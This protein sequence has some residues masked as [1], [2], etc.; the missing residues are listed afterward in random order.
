MRDILKQLPTM[1]EVFCRMFPDRVELDFTV[2]ICTYNG[3][4]RVPE[5]LNC[6]CW[7]LNVAD[8]AWEVIVVDNNSHDETAATVARYQKQ[9]PHPYPLRYVFEPKQGAGFA[10]QRAIQCAHSPLVGFL[11]DDNLPSLTWVSAAYHFA[12]RHP[13]AGVYGS[14]IRGDF[15]IN[16]PD[17]FDRIASLLALTE[18]GPSPI[19]YPPEKKVL[20]PG[21]GMV[22]RRQAWI[23]HVPPDKNLGIKVGKRDAAED[24][25]AVLY[26]QK[27]GW[28]IWYNPAMRL[29]HRIPKNRLKRDYL[30]GLCRGIGL[31]RYRTRM[32]SL[33]SWQ[34]PLWLWLYM[35]NDF[36]KV[37][38]HLIRH[39]R[40]VWTDTVTACEMT[41]Y[42]FSLI[43]PF[44]IWQ[45]SLKALLTPTA[46]GDASQETPDNAPVA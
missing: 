24:L 44:Y 32:L 6:L 16:P 34:R 23:D 12:Q 46:K 13:H 42:L 29:Y 27:G 33:P 2:A 38:R 45:K 8:I 9:W 5:V 17:H 40:A 19:L 18:R 14:R 36:R 3:A 15:E 37:I 10:R 35:V 22:V 28:Q 26:I 21:A 41:L 7:Q 25:E 30:L 20:P 4:D 31:S 43:S 11:D 1:R 39:G